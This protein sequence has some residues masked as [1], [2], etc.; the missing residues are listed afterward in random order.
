MAAGPLSGEYDYLVVTHLPSFYKV[1]LYNALSEHLRIGVVFIGETSSQRTDDFVAGE[2]RFDH[3]FLNAGPFEYAWHGPSVRKLWPIIRGTRYRRLLVNGWELPEFWCAVLASPRARNCLAL[4]SGITEGITAGW[5]GIAK[6]IFLGRLSQIFPSGSAQTALLA[7]L[8]W[9]GASSVTGGVGIINKRGVAGTRSPAPGRRFAFVGRLAGEKNLG[10]LVA[11]F[12]HIP[13]TLTIV[14]NGPELEQLRAAASSNV[15]FLAHVDNSAI[16]EVISAHDCLVLPSLRE[17]W[18]LVVEEALFRGVPVLVS[19]RCGAADLVRPGVNGWVF[20][21]G[22]SGSLEAAL[23]SADPAAL[24]FTVEAGRRMI[25]AKDREQVAA[26]RSLV[27]SMP[28]R[29]PIPMADNPAARR[30]GRGADVAFLALAR[31]CA[32]TLPSF[33]EFVKT[34]ES[35]GLQCDVLIGENGS[36]DG[37]RRMLGD[38]QAR[39]CLRLIDTAFMADIPGRYER[40]AGGREFLKNALVESGSA[41]VAVCVV[42][43][44][45]AMK[46]PPSRDGFL[47]ALEIL[48]TRKYFAVGATSDPVFYDL[49]SYEDDTQSFAWL[50]QAVIEAKRHPLGYFRYV[51]DEVYRRLPDFTRDTPME[52]ISSFNGLCLYRFDDYAGSSYLAGAEPAVCEHITF[53]RRLA[54]MTGERMVIS[55]ALTLSTPP[56][57]RPTGLI[58]FWTSRCLRYLRE[59]RP[60]LHR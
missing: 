29:K 24:G 56:E 20:D 21:P 4:E 26:Y 11:A 36:R 3:V 45:S 34:L 60:T 37:T 2:R 8:G 43:V 54:A 5:K 13:D 53:N 57:H 47:S 49:L 6:G 35:G 31:N 58:G 22:I 25:D 12:R 48:K 42:D 50:S 27:A 30:P 7:A 16:G 9:R 1:N 40:L 59:H 44:D 19:S 52:C 32:G 41:P 55:P 18:G 33:M 17:P 39:G 23:R 28:G 38:L 14:G 51:R 46:V 15:T 10:A